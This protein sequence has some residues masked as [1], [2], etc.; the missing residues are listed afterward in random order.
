MFASQAS[1]R[2]ARCGGFDGTLITPFRH[3]GKDTPTLNV[4]NWSRI[5][6]SAP[7][8]VSPY[9][10]SKLSWRCVYRAETVTSG[11]ASDLASAVSA[12]PCCSRTRAARKSARFSK[13]RVMNCSNE[14][15]PGHLLQ[16]QW[17][18]VV[19]WPPTQ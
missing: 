19:R 2:R 8:D 12:S 1:T 9:L 13:A 5:G 17:R 11:C 3:Q 6:V 7:E 10:F 14:S 18:A 16:G 15:A 4:L